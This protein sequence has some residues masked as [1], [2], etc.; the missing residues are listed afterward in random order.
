M[1]FDNRFDALMHEVCGG[2]GFCGGRSGD[3][4]VH[5]TDFIPDEGTVTADEFVILV[6]LGDG[7]DPARDPE[8]WQHLKDKIRD[9]FVRHMGAEAVDAQLLRWS[10]C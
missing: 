9:A 5:V 2:L 6:F 1:A 4:A 8:R 7:M 10:N 3:R